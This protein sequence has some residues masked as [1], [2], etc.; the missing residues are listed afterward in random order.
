[1]DSPSY[2][3]V[4]KPNHYAPLGLVSRNPISA[5]I[6]YNSAGIFSWHMA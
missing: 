6:S 4:A 1:M 2:L 3:T 5:Y